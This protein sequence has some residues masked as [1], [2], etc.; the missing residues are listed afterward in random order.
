VRVLVFGGRG[1]AEQA[2]LNVRL[3]TLHSEFKFTLLIEGGARGAD[4]LARTWAIQAGVPWVEEAVTDE[5]WKRLGKSAGH[6]RNQRMLDKHKPQMGIMF[7][8][9]SGTR[10][11]RGRLLTAGVRVIDTTERVR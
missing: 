3:S 9:G 1:Y 5:E 4:R 8:G 10:D 2:F 11:M 6:L 7:P